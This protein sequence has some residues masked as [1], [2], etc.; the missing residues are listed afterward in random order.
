[1][2][3]GEWYYY[4]TVRKRNGDQFQGTRGGRRDSNAALTGRGA[5][6]VECC[7]EPEPEHR[8]AWQ[9]AVTFTVPARQDQQS[10]KYDTKK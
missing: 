4:C 8:L 3:D 1:M 10:V 6:K 7:S 9:R 5:H 2:I